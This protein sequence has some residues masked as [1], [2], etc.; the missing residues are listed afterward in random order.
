MNSSNGAPEE[1][2]PRALALGLSAYLIWGFFPLYFRLLSPA[3][4]FE[5]IAHRAFWSLLASLTLIFLASRVPKL[6]ALLRDREVLVRLAV[7]G[8]LILVNWTVYVYA[9]LTDRTLDAALGYF[10]NPLVTVALARVVLKE[11]LTRAQGIA[12]ALGTISVLV[13]VVGM[14]YLPWISLVLAGSFSLYALVKKRVAGRVPPLEGLA[15]E[16][17]FV[18]PLMAAYYVYLLANGETSFHA[19][20]SEGAPGGWMAHLALLVGAGILTLLPLLLFAASA[21]GLPLAVMGLIQYI[22]PVMQM[23]IAVAIFHEPMAPARW[24]A[25]AFIW[26]A[27]G[28]LSSDWIRQLPRPAKD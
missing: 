16:T 26:V 8:G 18:T 28:V 9:V 14:G 15:V 27:L 10:I 23:L 2:H 1:V 5:V 11:R 25:T 13:M 19:L 6:R 12:I 3:G 20:Q 24:V 7:A 17:A 22:T 4:A 21:R